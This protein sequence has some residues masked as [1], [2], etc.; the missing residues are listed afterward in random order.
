M[1][2][3]ASVAGTRSL[4]ESNVRECRRIFIFCLIAFILTGL[5]HIYNRCAAS[6]SDDIPKA[7][8][9]T[10]FDY[11]VC[12]GSTFPNWDALFNLKKCRGG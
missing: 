5:L 9:R 7:G 2:L 11:M 10:V 8:T 4:V 3:S 12:L 1:L 6:S